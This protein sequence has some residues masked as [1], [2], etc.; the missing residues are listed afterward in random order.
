MRKI[1]KLYKKSE[2]NIKCLPRGIIA[3]ENGV[4]YGVFDSQGFFEKTS[5][6]KRKGTKGQIIPKIKTNE[7]LYVDEDVVYLCHIGRN[8]FGHFLLEQLSR[9]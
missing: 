7:I 8:H 1:R 2:P 9:G 5:V 4:G 6:Q 3:N